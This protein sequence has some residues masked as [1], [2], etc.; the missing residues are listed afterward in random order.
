MGR[1]LLFQAYKPQTQKRG[2][3]YP[4]TRSPRIP[5]R[6]DKAARSS[7]TVQRPS[8]LSPL[9]SS[10]N[11]SLASFQSRSTVFGEAKLGSSKRRFHDLTFASVDIFRCPESNGVQMVLVCPKAQ[12]RR[13][14]ARKSSP[15]RDTVQ[16]ALHRLAREGVYLRLGAKRHIVRIYPP[17]S[18][19]LGDRGF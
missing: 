15:Q 11:H 8:P 12:G 9:I 1:T 2:L 13:S 10:S 5:A 17:R 6:R 18:R 4:R 16:V 7:A 19:Q 14:A 3:R